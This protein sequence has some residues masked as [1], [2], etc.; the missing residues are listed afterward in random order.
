MPKTGYKPLPE[1]RA[2]VRAIAEYYDGTERNRRI[3]C[4][5]TAI[6]SVA[7]VTPEFLAA[8]QWLDTVDRRKEITVTRKPYYER[9]DPVAY[10]IHVVE[11]R[12]AAKIEYER[13]VK[14]WEEAGRP[15][16]P[17]A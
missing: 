8:L 17:P 3:Q 4:Y 16:H 12:R 2:V 9:G 14:L 6:E 11:G 5:A 7:P 15:T 1:D 10:L 13:A